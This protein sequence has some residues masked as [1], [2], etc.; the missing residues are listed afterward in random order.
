[1]SQYLPLASIFN[2]IDVA[3]KLKI[4]H[5]QNLGTVFF[6]FSQRDREFTLLPFIDNVQEGVALFHD[7]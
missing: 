7:S 5:K 4:N 3:R 6:L 2:L 1:M